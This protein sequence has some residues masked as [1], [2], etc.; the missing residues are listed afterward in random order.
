MCLH[1]EIKC[2]FYADDTQ[3]YVHLSHKNASALTKLNAYLQEVQRWIALS[4]LK[5]SPDKTEF[6]VFGS[7]AQRQK[8]SSHFP[9]NI[10]GN[11]LNPANIVK[12]LGVWFDA[13]FCFSEHVKKTCKGCFFQMPDLCRIR[14]YL[15]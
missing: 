1:P 3:L 4:K 2:Y 15:A 7:K 5:L 9:V 12:N 10:L 13:D 6:I 8:L 11:L 14:Q